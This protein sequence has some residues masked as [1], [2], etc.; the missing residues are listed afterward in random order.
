MCVSQYRDYTNAMKYT[1]ISK[2]EKFDKSNLRIHGVVERENFDVYFYWDLSKL[3][4]LTN[5]NNP[6]AIETL[7]NI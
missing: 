7:K 4:M 5:K 2:N 1:N 3:K 6:Y